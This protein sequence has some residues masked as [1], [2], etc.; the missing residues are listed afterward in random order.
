MVAWKVL[1]IAKIPEINKF[2]LSFIVTKY[3]PFG[4]QRE[5]KEDIVKSLFSSMRALGATTSR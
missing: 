2:T 3:D 1:H 4:D 5:A